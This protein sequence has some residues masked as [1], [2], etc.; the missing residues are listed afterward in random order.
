M[1]GGR[2]ARRFLGGPHMRDSTSR[3]GCRR[4]SVLIGA[5]ALLLGSARC[6][7]SNGHDCGSVM[8][9]CVDIFNNIDRSLNRRPA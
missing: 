3:R 1:M 2:H 6:S 7:N 8:R 9:G 4:S 5:L